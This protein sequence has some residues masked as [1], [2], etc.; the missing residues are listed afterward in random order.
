M[1]NALISAFFERGWCLIRGLSAGTGCQMSM[2][3]RGERG[4]EALVTH[5][6]LKGLA[7]ET[8]TP[9]WAV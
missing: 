7:V 9:G 6:V 2:N 5:V 4:H 3:P 1:K 8:L